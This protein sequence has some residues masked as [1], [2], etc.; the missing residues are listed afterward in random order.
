MNY[1]KKFPCGECGKMVKPQE[2]HTLEDCRKWQK[3]KN[4]E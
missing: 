3:K 4:M 1:N 2:K